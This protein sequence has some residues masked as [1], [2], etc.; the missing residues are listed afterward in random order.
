MDSTDSGVTVRSA[1]PSTMRRSVRV[2]VVILAIG[3][4]SGCVEIFHYVGY[5]DDGRLEVSFSFAMQKAIFEM[6]AGLDGSGSVDF[7]EEFGN[8]D[9]E[10]TGEFPDWVEVEA[11]QIDTE[12]EYG[13]SMTMRV[14]EEQLLLAEELSE[15]PDDV[16]FLP[17]RSDDSI[18]IYLEG[19]GGGDETDEMAAAFLASAKYRLLISAAYAGSISSAEYEVADSGETLPIDVREFGEV[20]LLELPMLYLFSHGGDSWIRIRT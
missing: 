10:I 6:A 18:L 5:T 15:S 14:D 17:R 1:G 13:V 12:L 8:L 16:A 11:G 20:Y 2:A 3:L 19:M 7:E 4:L 9:T